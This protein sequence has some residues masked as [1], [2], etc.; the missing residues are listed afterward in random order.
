MTKLRIRGIQ[1]PNFP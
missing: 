1:H